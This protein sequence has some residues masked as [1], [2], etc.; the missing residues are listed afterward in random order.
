MD[1]DGVVKWV[2][3]GAKIL[4]TDEGPKEAWVMRESELC[5]CSKVVVEAE[6]ER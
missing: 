2:R 5:R 1:D 6:Q 4:E 3:P